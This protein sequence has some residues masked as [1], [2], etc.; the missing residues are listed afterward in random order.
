MSVVPLDAALAEHAEQIASANRKHRAGL[1]VGTQVRSSALALRAKVAGELA[2]ER[3]RA[4]LDTSPSL[5][6]VFSPQANWSFTTLQPADATLE[7][8]VAALRDETRKALSELQESLNAH[9]DDAAPTSAG[10]VWR[11]SEPHAAFS[12]LSV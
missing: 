4:L 7:V 12:L 11:R 3:L 8:P 5:L 6:Y 10:I 2:D 9:A 1:S